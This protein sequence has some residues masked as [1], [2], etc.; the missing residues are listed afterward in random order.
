LNDL[1]AETMGDEIRID[2]PADILFDFDKFNIRPDAA[3]ALNKLLIII[4]A[5]SPNASIRIA[6][7]TDAIGSDAYNQTLSRN[8]ANAVKNWL[9]GKGIAATRMTTQ[10]FGE[11]RPIAANTKPN[12]SDNPEGRQQNRRV[13]VIINTRS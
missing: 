8:R 4:Q 6:G 2:L 3:A 7:H 1:G 9:S 11:S 5:Q 10:G 12:G 13:Q